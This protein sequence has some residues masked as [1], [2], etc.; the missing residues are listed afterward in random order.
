M[1]PVALD[2]LLAEQADGG[3]AQCAAPRDRVQRRDQER[4]TGGLGWRRGE[5]R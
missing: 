3:L 2:L 5:S 4:P 1:M